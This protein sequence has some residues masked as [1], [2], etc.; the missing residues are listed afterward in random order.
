MGG[1][2]VSTGEVPLLV[3]VGE[4]ELVEVGELEMVEASRNNCLDS[5]EDGKPESGC[6]LVPP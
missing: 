4:L 3:V 1:K 6:F 2:V 5:G